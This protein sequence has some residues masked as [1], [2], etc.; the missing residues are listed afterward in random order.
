MTGLLIYI[1]G[2]IIAG[3][4][5]LYYTY[6]ASGK[7]VVIDIFQSMAFSILSWYGFIIIIIAI[8]NGIGFFK[9]TLLKKEKKDE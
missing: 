1:T 4:L 8:L 9:M 5:Y 3:I 2:S 6:E 7:V